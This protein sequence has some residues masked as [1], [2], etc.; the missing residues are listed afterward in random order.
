MKIKEDNISRFLLLCGLFAPVMMMAIIFVLG[1]VTPDYNPVSDSIC[2]MG[3]PGRP[4]AIVLNGG[5]VVY[6]TLMAGAAYGLARSISNISTA[7]RVAILLCVHAIGTM[8]LGI[9]PDSLELP[10]NHFSD[11]LLHNSVSAISYLP[12]LAA[13]FIF[14]N[15]ARQEKAL[16]VTGVLGVVI[17]VMNFPMPVINTIEA[18]DP[19]SGLLQ[20]VL[21]GASFSWLALT[22]FLLYRRRYRI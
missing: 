15:I 4:L 17:V 16:K 13:I 21:A 22:F 5:Y 20:R 2:Q 19:V 3:I 1:Q 6:G 14:R 7:K 9:F 10:T 18:I 12:L 8:L 11:D